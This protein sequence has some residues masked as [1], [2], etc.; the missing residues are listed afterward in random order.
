VCVCVCVKERERERERGRKQPNK[1]LFFCLKRIRWKLFL[2]IL[3]D[4][5]SLW[6]KEDE[7]KEQ[8]RSRF[9]LHH[10]IRE[11]LGIFERQ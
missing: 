4:V 1:T 9:F 5:K 7:T 6:Q 8:S 2:E 10:I 11:I 3:C